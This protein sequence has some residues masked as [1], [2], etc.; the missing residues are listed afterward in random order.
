[1]YY[2]PKNLICLTYLAFKQNFKKL[3]LAFEKI[4]PEID[5]KFKF[6][7]IIFILFAIYELIQILNVFKR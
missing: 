5:Y 1:M 3:N 2:D 6:A 4:F 7:R